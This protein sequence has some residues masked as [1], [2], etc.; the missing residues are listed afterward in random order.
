MD[1]DIFA[2]ISFSDLSNM[3]DA[4]LEAVSAFA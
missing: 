1:R 4:E 2:G 3:T